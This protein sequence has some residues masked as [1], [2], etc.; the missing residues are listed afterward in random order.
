MCHGEMGSKAAT[1][2][3]VGNA[4]PQQPN[5][6]VIVT[7]WLQRPSAACSGNGAQCDATKNVCAGLQRARNCEVILK[8]TRR[9]TAREASERETLA[10]NV[11]CTLVLQ[12]TLYSSYG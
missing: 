10:G 5:E 12:A 11:Q 9:Q 2:S 7:H 1:G 4:H 8:T 3:P 6:A